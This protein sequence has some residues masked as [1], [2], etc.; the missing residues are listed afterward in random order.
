MLL[1]RRRLVLGEGNAAQITGHDP[2]TEP[3]FHAIWPVIAAF[4]PPVVAPQTRNP[5]LD[6]RPP[7][8]AALEA[9][10]ALQC[11]ACLREFAR[12]WDGHQLH[13]DFGENL[14][15]VG[16]MHATIAG[17]QTRRPTKHL[18]MMLHGF[19]RLSVLM[20]LLEKR[21]ARHDAALDLIEDDMPPKLDLG[22]AFVAGDGPR[23]RLKQA[24]HFVG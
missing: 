7:A 17:H 1:T 10:G 14:L 15:S 12:G 19:Q 20:G 21:V 9:P 11:L 2:Q 4:A 8:I 22:S 3:A 23:V 24:Q 18:P 16:G 6:T 13:A 5:A